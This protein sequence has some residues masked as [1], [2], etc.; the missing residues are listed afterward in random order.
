MNWTG[1]IVSTQIFTEVSSPPVEGFAAALQCFHFWFYLDGFLDGA[2]NESL[3]VA[4]VFWR[5]EE[6]G[7]KSNRCLRVRGCLTMCSGFSN[8]LPQDGLR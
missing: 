6:S 5:E 2:K 4:Q 7:K 8:L 1:I 3:A